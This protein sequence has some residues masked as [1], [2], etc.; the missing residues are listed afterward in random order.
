MQPA[1]KFSHEK[2]LLLVQN[3]FNKRKR[4]SEITNALRLV[5]GQGD[6]LKG[7]VID[8]YNAHWMV[9]VYEPSWASRLEE[10][11]KFIIEKFNP[12]YLIF[13]DALSKDDAQA[14]Y[15]HLLYGQENPQTVVTENGLKFGVNLNDHRNVGLFLDMRANRKKVGELCR[16]RLVLNC[17]SYTCS[18]GVYARH[19]DAASVVNVDGS[20]KALERGK[21]NYEL[22]GIVPASDEFIPADAVGYLERAVMKGNFFDVIILDPPSFSR[23]EGKVFSVR[24]DMKRLIELALRIMKPSGHLFTATN[25]SSFS[26][27]KLESDVKDRAKYLGRPIRNMIPLGQDSDFRGSGMMRESFLAALLIEL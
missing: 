15:A 1:E 18:F 13:K 26:S 19:F 17:F 21:Q 14:V 23:H 25:F 24:E 9:Q 8:R 7:L 2:L 22:N 11:Q 10:I 27:D 4:L 16:A 3:A 20:R 12:Q 6:G 5:N